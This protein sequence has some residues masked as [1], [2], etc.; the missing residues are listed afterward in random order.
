MSGEGEWRDRDEE[1]TYRDRRTD[2]QTHTPKENER[3]IEMVREHEPAQMGRSDPSPPKK[4]RSLSMQKLPHPGA[5]A[6]EG[7]QQMTWP[8]QAGMCTHTH[9]QP[10]FDPVQRLRWAMKHEL[11]RFRRLSGS[12][13]AT[14]ERLLNGMTSVQ[15]QRRPISFPS[16]CVVVVGMP[17]RLVLGLILYG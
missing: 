9:T 12:A 13:S 17:W 5:S 15:P 4:S 10:R 6:E 7:K 8:A 11:V 2:R 16:C 1:G 3:E 14:S